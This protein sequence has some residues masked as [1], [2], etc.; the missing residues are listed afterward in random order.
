MQKENKIR[1]NYYKIALAKNLGFYTY[2]QLNNY[3]IYKVIN[4]VTRVLIYEGKSRYK[5]IKLI[6]NF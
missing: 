3:P 6:E 4:L 1:K 5:A 2:S